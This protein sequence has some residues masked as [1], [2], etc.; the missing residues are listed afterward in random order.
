[1]SRRTLWLAIVLT[2]AA[3]LAASAISFSSELSSLIIHAEPGEEVVRSFE[4]HLAQG[5]SGAN[6]TARVEDWWTSEDGLRSFYRPPGSV[7]QSCGPWTE[8][9]PVDAKVEA[10]GTLRIRVT[11][12]VPSDANPGGYWCVLTVDEQPDPLAP[13]GAVEVRFL[14]SISVGI[15]VY[16]PGFD[17]AAKITEVAVADGRASVTVVNEGN[18]PARVDG[19][20]EFY[21]AGETSPVAIAELPRSTLLLAPAPSRRIAV[22]LPAADVLPDGRYLVRAVL[23]IGLEHFLG[24]Q[25]ELDVRRERTL[26]ARDPKGSGR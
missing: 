22:D 15:F 8:I 12:A 26:L 17:R 14:S 24:A 16:L 3:P 23:D 4:L 13:T 11:T 21:R 9:D 7:Q 19:Q 5:G 10:G 6:F 25:K 2:F 1:M 20:F 18:A